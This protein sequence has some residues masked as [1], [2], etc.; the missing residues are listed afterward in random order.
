MQQ[1]ISFPDESED[2]SQA[3]PVGNADQP[4]PEPVLFP[5]VEA[6]NEYSD[7][8]DTPA[9]GESSNPPSD[10]PDGRAMTQ[11]ELLLAQHRQRMLQQSG[12]A[13]LTPDSSSNSGELDEHNLAFPGGQLANERAGGVS[14]REIIMQQQRD[15]LLRQAGVNPGQS[16]E[17]T[18]RDA[19][20]HP[21]SSH[22][23]WLTRRSAWAILVISLALL[24][25]SG[26]ATTGQVG[27]LDQVAGAL[28]P[29]VVER[30]IAETVAS[31]SDAPTAPTT[32]PGAA[33]PSTP[34]ADAP[35]QADVRASN[36]QSLRA[37]IANTNGVGVSVRG[38]CVNEARA[39][40]LL[41]EGAVVR[42]IGRGVGDCSGWSVVRAGA[43]TSWVEDDFL[44]AP[45]TR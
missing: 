40:G 15:I 9:N 31:F 44:A 19:S 13:P 30:W 3:D 41:E 42:I 20:G 24:A 12:D 34:G 6:T 25:L 37:Q 23:R 29:D 5:G 7:A 10:A 26:V 14:Q 22:N 45:A 28:T 4:L 39:P 1:P 43:K 38:I 11:R 17:S 35:G 18:P 33:S 21:A 27:P 36:P 32:N 2:V 16:A 8:D